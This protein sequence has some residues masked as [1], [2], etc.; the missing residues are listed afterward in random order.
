MW[1]PVNRLINQDLFCT[2]LY[3]YGPIFCFG[4]RTVDVVT[5]SDLES[6]RRF[7]WGQSTCSTVH[8]FIPSIALK[9]AEMGLAIRNSITK[10]MRDLS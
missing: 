1:E 2:V 8:I 7:R 9:L 3:V 4:S 10:N 5:G 6:V